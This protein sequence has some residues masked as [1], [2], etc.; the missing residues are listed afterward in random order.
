M[1]FGKK[2]SD[3]FLEKDSRKEAEAAIDAWISDVCGL[4]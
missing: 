4:K 2:T 3:N 1:S